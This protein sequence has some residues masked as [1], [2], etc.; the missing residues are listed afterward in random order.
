MC[1]CRLALK[2][3]EQTGGHLAPY[4][5]HLARERIH[6]R[7]NGNTASA[8]NSLM[9]GLSV[10]SDVDSDML[11]GL[12]LSVVESDLLTDDTQNAYVEHNIVES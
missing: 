10:G 11:S 4:S 9:S 6:G 3:G 5:N 7:I 8:G 12:H 1:A 2:I